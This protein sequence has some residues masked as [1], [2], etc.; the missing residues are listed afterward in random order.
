MAD[1]PT[2]QDLLDELARLF[3]DEVREILNRPEKKPAAEPQV[4]DKAP[5]SSS[6]EGR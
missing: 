1:K 6:N 4:R 2:R 5:A 3:A